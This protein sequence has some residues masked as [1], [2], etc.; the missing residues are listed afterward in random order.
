MDPQMTSIN[1]LC[2]ALARV[3]YC[4][5]NGISNLP[6]E[7]KLRLR[8]LYR[9]AE[10]DYIFEV[11]RFNNLGLKSSEQW[12]LNRINLDKLSKNNLH[13]ESQLKPNKNKIVE[14]VKS[15]TGYGLLASDVEEILPVPGGWK[16]SISNDSL[17]FTGS[18]KIKYRQ[19]EEAL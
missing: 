9:D 19:L 12:A 15:T 18:F 6:H 8:F 4:K 10:G 5:D 16:I 14:K 3:E 7:D 13:F 17:R 11:E 2:I 1:H